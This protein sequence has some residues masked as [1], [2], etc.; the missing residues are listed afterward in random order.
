MRL[1]FFYLAL[2]AAQGFLGAALHP[3]SPPDFFLLAAV[4]LLWRLPPWQLVLVGYGVGLAQDIMGHGQLGIHA[5]ALA[6]AM[7]GALMV[8][9]QLSPEGIFPQTLVVLAALAG[10]WLTLVPLLIWLTGEPLAIM[11]ILQVAPSEIV[12]TV[13]V[14]FLIMPWSN[15]LMEQTLLLRK[16][17]L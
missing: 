13:L 14:S 17:L 11:G 12:L 3:L 10:K 8:K 1:I 15:A 7:M 6:G 2:L 16:E 5:L 4:A 9:A